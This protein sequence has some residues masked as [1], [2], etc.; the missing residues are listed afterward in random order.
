M[1][2]LGTAGLAALVLSACG[3]PRELEPLDAATE[4]RALAAY[5]EREYSEYLRDYI[6]VYVGYATCSYDFIDEDVLNVL[7]DD[8]LRAMT[9]RGAALIREEHPSDVNGLGDRQ[10]EYAASMAVLTTM[11]MSANALTA[12]IGR[13]Y[14]DADFQ[15]SASVAANQARYEWLQRFDIR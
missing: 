12:E 14:E 15:C 4:S 13:T 11:E 8:V 9:S 5:I 6:H 3:A 2:H 1:R 7:A 10:I